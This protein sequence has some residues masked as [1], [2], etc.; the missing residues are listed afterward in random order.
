[1]KYSGKDGSASVALLVDVSNIVRNDSDLKGIYRSVCD[2]CGE[3]A[4]GRVYLD[5]GDS[6]SKEVSTVAGSLGFDDP[7]QRDGNSADLLLT[8]DAVELACS[9]KYRHINAIAIASNDGHFIPAAEV[10]QSYGKDFIAVLYQRTKSLARIAN[11][12]VR[13][14]GRWGGRRTRDKNHCHRRPPSATRL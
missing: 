8:R 11:Q 4:I 13:V 6:L 9:P 2:Q 12:T 1:M 14:K 7:I 10:I 3:I 5:N